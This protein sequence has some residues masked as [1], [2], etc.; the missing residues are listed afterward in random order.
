MKD[1][2]CYHCDM[3]TKDVIEYFGSQREAARKLG[4][5][6][7]SISNWGEYP[8]DAR[9]LHIEK[10]TRKKLKAEPGCLERLITP[11]AHHPV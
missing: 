4:L 2:C 8:P 10:V 9:Q 3:R 5:S 11:P 6:Q 1:S 7:P